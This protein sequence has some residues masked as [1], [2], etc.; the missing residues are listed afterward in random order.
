[1]SIHAVVVGHCGSDGELRVLPDGTEVLNFNVASNEGR[2]DKATTTWTRVAIFGK[3]AKSLSQYITK[4]K[5]VAVS[6]TLQN[7]SYETNGEKRM[8][9]ECRCS[10]I[11][12]L[13]SKDGGGR[14]Q[15][16]ESA[17]ADGAE[18]PLPF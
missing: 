17:P 2:G 18:E 10:E 8:S 4:G 14:T 15:T 9:L 3:R 6:G 5:Q 12:L 11:E 7:R 1:M 13:G 16:S